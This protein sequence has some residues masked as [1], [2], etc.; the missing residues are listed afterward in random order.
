MDMQKDGTW[1][2]TN[3]VNLLELEAKASRKCKRLF[4]QTDRHVVSKVPYCPTT[5]AQ[6]AV[7]FTIRFTMPLMWKTWQDYVQN[8]LSFFVFQGKPYW[9][10]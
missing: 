10:S 2:H 6:P 5:Y 8:N 7:L 9:L 1:L 3:E 4:L